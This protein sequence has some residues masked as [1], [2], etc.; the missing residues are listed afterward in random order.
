PDL[1]RPIP[2]AL[3]LYVD[4]VNG[5]DSYNGFTWYRAFKTIQAACNAAT[6]GSEIVLAP[7]PHDVGA[8]VSVTGD[9]LLTIIGAKP[10][11]RRQHAGVSSTTAQA[12]LYSTAATKP[13]FFI[14]VLAD[15]SNNAFGWAFKN[16]YI[17]G[18]TLALGGAGI[19]ALN[20]NRAIVEDVS[21]RVVLG[22]TNTGDDNRYLIKSIAQG[23]AGNDASWWTLKN[24]VTYGMRGLYA[25][26]SNYWTFMGVS[27]MGVTNGSYKPAGPSVYMSGS[28][29]N[30]SGL[31]VEGWEDGV[32]LYNCRGAFAIG[33][34][35]EWCTRVLKLTNCY[36][37]LIM[38]NSRAGAGESAVLDE[39][40]RNNT[41]IGTDRVYRTGTSVSDIRISK[42]G[43]TPNQLAGGYLGTVYHSHPT[44]P[45]PSTELLPHL[46]MFDGALAASGIVADYWDG[47]A[48][49][50]WAVDTH[51][52][53]LLNGVGVTIDDTHKKCRFRMGSFV[54]GQLPTLIFGRLAQSNGTLGNVTVRTY[55]DSGR[56]VI[57][58]EYTTILGMETGS[59][60]GAP[61][62]VRGFQSSLAIES[63]YYVEV[64]FDLGLTTGQTATLQR[65]HA[66]GVDPSG[67]M[68]ACRILDGRLAPEGVVAARVG[69]FYFAHGTSTSD[70][71]NTGLY[72]K[73]S[74][75]GTTTGWTRATFGPTPVAASLN[76]PSVSAGSYQDLTIAVPG[77]VVGDCVT[78]GIP[79]AAVM[80]GIIYSMWVSAADTVT[81]RATNVTAGALDPPT[82]TFKAAIVR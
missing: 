24:V 39:N 62:R 65:L 51:A 48:W 27:F 44:V 31:H 13:D 32:H 45:N 4:P 12:H 10:L 41:I 15:G 82:G 35:S 54:A 5:N 28:Q 50:T 43:V 53:H 57:G 72:R 81:V 64:E 49:Q 20:V 25:T 59:D 70:T 67:G 55:T 61:A 36:D 23:F 71:T 16:L 7:M 22:S 63:G 47:T 56:T 8:G 46:G 9:K 40:G 14:K 77:A 68:R 60:T 76:F 38:V 33:L 26:D 17:D 80:A 29:P 52:L 74:G 6:I 21:G 75:D 3:R 58:Q 37:S 1:E 11:R 73:E 30:L 19:H 42:R 78:P 34:A 18:D 2:G 66:W 69:D 79:N